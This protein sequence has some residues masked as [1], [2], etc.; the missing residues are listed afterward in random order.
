MNESIPVSDL[1]AYELIGSGR[2]RGGIYTMIFPNLGV[3]CNIRRMKEN[4]DFEVRADLKFI[5]FRPTSRGHLRRGRVI[6][7]STDNRHKMSKALAYR[8]NEV[9]WDAVMEILSEVVLE[10]YRT[11]APVETLTGEVDIEAQKKWL[12]DP[13]LEQ[14]SLTIMYAPGSSGKSWI[15]QYLTVLVDAG[16]STNEYQV[17]PAIVLYLDWE[18]TKQELDSRVTMIRRGLNLSG[19]SNIKYRTMYAGVVSDLERIQEIIIEERISLVVIDSVASACGGEAENAK[20]VLDTF[21]G[22]RSLNVSVLAIDHTN[23]ENQLFGSVYK[24][25]EARNVFELVKNQESDEQKIVIGLFHRKTNNGPLIRDRG[26]EVSFTKDQA[27]FSE[28]NIRDTSLEEH[29]G[30]RE[31]IKNMLR[32]GPAT[33]LDISIALGKGEGSIRTV[34]SNGVRD[35]IFTHIKDIT[36]GRSTGKY[37]LAVPVAKAPSPIEDDGGDEEWLID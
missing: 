30:V 10:D 18:T 36:A 28:V 15:A 12:I 20:V 22:L 34:L 26:T 16:R 13:I 5:S 17:E 37:A 6:L 29:Q 19:K 35:G 31:R 7:T 27:I 32:S 4:S 9:E 3:E 11:G 14:G 21:N 25:N 33:P 1:Y 23:K 2:S 8:D 24:F